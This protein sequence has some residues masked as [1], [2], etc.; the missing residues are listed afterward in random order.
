MKSYIALVA[1]ML[2]WAISPIVTKLGLGV[3]PPL[4]LVTLRFTMAV[5]LML[6]IGLASKSLVKIE[7]KDIP[8]FLFGGFVQPFLYYIFESYSLKLLASPTIAE[9][10]F[11]A[12]PIFAPIFAWLF[13]RERVTLNNI[14]GI[15]I[16]S[17]GMFMLILN[18]GSKSQFQ[19]GSLWGFA[20]ALAAVFS[21][22]IYTIILRKIP[23]RYNSLSIVFYI[24][25]SGLIFFLPTWAFVDG[26][27]F[28]AIQPTWQ[29]F[30]SIGYLAAFSSVVAFVL[31]CYA[32]RRIGVTRANA[33][34]NVRPIFTALIMLI[35][36]GESLPIVKWAGI[37][38][39]IFG[40]FV[41]QSKPK[42]FRIFAQK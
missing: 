27:N 14:V 42:I 3:F 12:S 4:T 35:F 7:K 40:L 34:N 41:C 39:V 19:I 6:T 31:F 8:L 5:L 17:V 38:M 10:I 11:S 13:I 37:F 16:S 1:S 36:F 18:F 25:L 2:I 23:T 33:F 24:Q 9:A 30:A 28:A 32:V 20:L 21:A 15:V 26:Q 22:V 29:G